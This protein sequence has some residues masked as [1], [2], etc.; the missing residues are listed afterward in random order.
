MTRIIVDKITLWVSIQKYAPN[1]PEGALDY[2]LHELSDQPDVQI[3]DYDA[4]EYELVKIS[5]TGKE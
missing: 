3:L 5:K 2:I 1:S 4:E